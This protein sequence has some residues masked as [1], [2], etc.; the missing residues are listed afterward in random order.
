MG[1]GSERLNHAIPPAVR[2]YR[3]GNPKH[4]AITG[5]VTG[6]K[7]ARSR[8]A[9]TIA[10]AVADVVKLLIMWGS[11][12]GTSMETAFKASAAINKGGELHSR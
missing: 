1:Q 6:T 9:L 4:R 5:A 12:Y 11:R 10:I 7:K 2:E 8:E 3:Y